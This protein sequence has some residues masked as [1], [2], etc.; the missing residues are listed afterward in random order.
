MTQ[1]SHA[2]AP[3]MPSAPAAPG[4]DRQPAVSAKN[5]HSTTPSTSAAPQAS[6]PRA[7]IRTHP[8][9]G[10]RSA[11]RGERDHITARNHS[12]RVKT[13]KWALPMVVVG[14]LGVF[15]ASIAM[16]LVP[17]VEIT[18]DSSLIEDGRVVMKNPRMK[19]VDKQNRAFEV[20]A[21]RAITDLANPAAVELE[22]IDAKVPVNAST[23]ANVK[24][25]QG[26]Y[27]NTEEVLLLRNNVRMSGARG[28]DISMEDARINM[29]DGTLASDKPVEVTSQQAEISAN[30][31]SVEDNGARI[32]FIERV[33]MT[34]KQ[35]VTRGQEPLA[36]GVDVGTSTPVT[37]LRPA[38]ASP[39]VSQ[40]EA[41]Q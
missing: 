14:T 37:Q 17:N 7:Q 22:G 39:T 32:V 10:S 16:N 13:L 29:K 15:G 6:D 12:R 36:T 25:D 28:M 31:I 23:F 24:A 34:I 9:A 30:A 8:P 18:M 26:F 38:L 4:V 1:I 27:N 41:T 21:T 11:A 19:G 5:T 33:R 35:P 2:V 20:I 40:N 3:P